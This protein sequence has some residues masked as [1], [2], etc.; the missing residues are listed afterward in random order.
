MEMFYANW[1]TGISLYDAF[2]KTQNVMRTEYP[3][4]PEKWAAFVLVE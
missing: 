4:N 2:R 1:M 3:N